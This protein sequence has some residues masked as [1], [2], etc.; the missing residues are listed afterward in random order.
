[1]DSNGEE[2]NCSGDCSLQL[3]G[4]T[5]SEKNAIYSSE[6]AV[7]VAI[8]IGNTGFYLSEDLWTMNTYITRNGGLDWIEVYFIF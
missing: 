6:S 8:G 2:I 4:R 7:G 5:T 3:R 1:M